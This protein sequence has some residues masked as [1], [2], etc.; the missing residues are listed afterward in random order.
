ML[1]DFRQM[2]KS[3]LTGIPRDV[4]LVILLVLVALA[5]FGL[6]Y[7]AGKGAA[8]QTFVGLRVVPDMTSTSSE[9]VIASRTGTAYY[10]PWCGGAGRISAAQAIWFPSGTEARTHGYTPARNCDGL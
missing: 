7:L 6:G 1:P 4:L 8:A 3:V 10:W 9:A 5:S 2:C